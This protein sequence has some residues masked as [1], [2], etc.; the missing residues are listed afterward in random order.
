MEME[1][2]M[3][4]CCCW[5]DAGYWCC[6]PDGW[7]DGCFAERIGR[8]GRGV[9]AGRRAEGLEGIGWAEGLRNGTRRFVENVLRSFERLP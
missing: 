5:L 8:A 7:I 1:M 9:G 6:W 3:R 4:E 2:V